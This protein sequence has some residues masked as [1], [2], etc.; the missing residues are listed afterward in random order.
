MSATDASRN[1]VENWNNGFKIGQ[2]VRVAVNGGFIVTRTKTKAFFIMGMSVVF[3]DQIDRP[4]PLSTVAAM[5]E[6]A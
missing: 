4:V 5:R 2:L 6:P 3:V 1:H